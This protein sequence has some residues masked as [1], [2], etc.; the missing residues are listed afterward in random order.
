MNFF[1]YIRNDG[2]IFEFTNEDLRNEHMKRL[3]RNEVWDAGSHNGIPVNVI[4]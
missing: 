1:Y 3:S 2:E 4:K